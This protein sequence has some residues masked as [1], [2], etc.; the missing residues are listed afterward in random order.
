MTRPGV[1][2][3]FLSTALDTA[4]SVVQ[5][6]AWRNFPFRT[7]KQRNQ[8]EKNGQRGEKDTQALSDKSHKSSLSLS[9]S[10]SRSTSTRLDHE[11]DTGKTNQQRN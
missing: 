6:G 2:P 1:W 3:F 7:H 9:P 5:H 10:N 4:T 8:I 11:Y